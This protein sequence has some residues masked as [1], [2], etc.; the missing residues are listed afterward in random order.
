MPY[1]VT[2]MWNLKYDTKSLTC[3]IER[4]SQTQKADLWL[5]RSGGRMS[6]LGI[7]GS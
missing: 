7:W 1:A 5:P 4:D 6:G 3:R 2:Y